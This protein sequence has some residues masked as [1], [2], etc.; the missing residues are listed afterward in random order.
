MKKTTKNKN[1]IDKLSASKITD[2]LLEGKTKNLV[3]YVDPSLITLS[4]VIEDIFCRLTFALSDLIQ[5]G[6][7]QLPKTKIVIKRKVLLDVLNILRPV[8]SAANYGKPSVVSSWA[9]TAL[10]EA[11]SLIAKERKFYEKD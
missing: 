11:S 1:I 3:T 6:K 2:L 10:V 4:F 5:V 8:A 7:I 9:F